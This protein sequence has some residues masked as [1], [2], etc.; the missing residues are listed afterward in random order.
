M[1]QENKLIVMA[2]DIDTAYTDQINV[3]VHN[4]SDTTTTI[5][6]ETFIAQMI[7]D[8]AIVLKITIK[9]TKI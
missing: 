3:A 6:Q 4:I 9:M 8:K 7:C 2:Q 1:T 5:P